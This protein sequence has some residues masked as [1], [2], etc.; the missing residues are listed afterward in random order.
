MFSND[1]LVVLNT[2]FAKHSK[3]SVMKRFALLSTFIF[4]ICFQSFAQFPLNIGIAGGASYS[5]YTN[6]IDSL[7]PIGAAGWHAGAFA[8]L[9]LK[10]WYVGA[11]V[12]IASKPGKFESTTG[13]T[14]G[15]ISVVGLDVPMMLGYKLIDAKVFN[16]R[17][18]AGPNLHFKFSDEVKT[19]FNGV[20]VNS[21]N[22]VEISDDPQVAALI[23]AGCDIA[24][25]TVDVRYQYQFTNSSSVSNFDL[26][27][28]M[29][30]ATVGW[31]FL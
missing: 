7:N 8:R 25:I 5:S 14:E 27:N 4:A 21:G 28:Q 31:K 13:K 15:E 12:L 29:I 30:Q 2:N 26:N 19:S 20:N 23:G 17:A 1:L 24:F 9:K 3:Y 18:Y 11:D 6:N 10:K 16:L 22:T